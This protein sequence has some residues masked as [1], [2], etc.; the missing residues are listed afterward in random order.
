MAIKPYQ[1][2]ILR[3]Y[4]DQEHQLSRLYDTFGRQFPE[5]KAFWRQ[6]AKEEEMHAHIIA[7]LR[8]AAEKGTL[9]FDEGKIK[10]YTLSAMID[11][12]TL[13]QKDAEEGKMG[14][15]RALAQAM[16]L[17]SAL[18]EKGVFTHFEALSDKAR[19]VLKRLNGDTLDHVA[20][21]RHMRDT[22]R[23]KAPAEVSPARKHPD[24]GPD[25]RDGI[26]WSSALSVGDDRLDRQHRLLFDIIEDLTQLRAEGGR[27]SD[28][29]N[30]ITR[31]IG[32]SDA[33]FSCEDTVMI[34]TEFP[35]F[36]SHRREHQYFI[37]RVGQF[38]EGYQGGRQDLTEDMMSFLKE[39]WF[40]HVS[41]TD[42]RYARWVRSH[43][44][45]P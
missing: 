10:T 6:L 19:S 38:L 28:I 5:D 39:W 34:D 18:I 21:V 11:R 4:E 35:L 26:Q 20:R 44:T 27:R 12:L 3:L 1:E 22:D 7:R 37:E 33:H 23:G 17:E 29:V 45:T 24:A 41:E 36:A 15:R 31:L 2:K 14:R 13:L 8:D 25:I 42:M 16:D 40:N 9:L 43:G 30:L 32:F